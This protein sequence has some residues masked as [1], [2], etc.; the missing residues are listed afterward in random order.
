MNKKEMINYLVFGILTTIVNIVSYWLL[1]KIFNI[2]YRVATTIAWF[3]SV[4]FAYITNKVFVF[5]SKGLDINTMVKEFISFIFFRILS[6]LIDLGMMIVLV[7]WIKTNDILAK[8]IANIV[9]V[10]VNYVASKYYIF[11][12]AKK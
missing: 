2:D 3:I 7:E 9:V 6:Y 1:T 11:R 5:N 12:N 4:V 10:I 8:I